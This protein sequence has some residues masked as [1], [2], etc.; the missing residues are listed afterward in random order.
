MPVVVGCRPIE[1]SRGRTLSTEE[2][3]EQGHE[4]RASSLESV[5]L[6][7]ENEEGL[8]GDWTMV[9]SDDDKESSSSDSE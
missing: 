6:N 4:T 5:D 1:V 9:D 8:G 7:N 3:P 2:R